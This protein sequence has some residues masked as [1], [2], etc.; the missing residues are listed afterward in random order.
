MIDYEML[1]VKSILHHW[2]DI[3]DADTLGIAA[4]L[5]AFVT[6]SI[7]WSVLF[8]FLFLGSKWIESSVT[9]LKK[10]SLTM[11]CYVAA[12]ASYQMM[13]IGVVLSMT[14]QPR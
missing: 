13:Q 10:K 1:V 8:L 4:D 3:D 5:L 7:Q 12:H 9:L 6:G 14:E 11:T 2:V